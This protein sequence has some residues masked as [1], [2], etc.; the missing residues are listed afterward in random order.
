VHFLGPSK[1]DNRF[2]HFEQAVNDTFGVGG[3]AAKFRRLVN[4]FLEPVHITTG[5]KGAACTGE[6]NQITV[7]IGFGFRARYTYATVAIVIIAFIK[8]SF[9][10]LD[11][12]ELRHA[13][14]SL[15]LTF[16]LWAVLVGSTIIGCYRTGS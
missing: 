11:L 15:R 12:M 4:H 10:F 16:E 8:V 13:P 2:L 6:N 7:F 5:A 14:L 1:T 3:D 9:V